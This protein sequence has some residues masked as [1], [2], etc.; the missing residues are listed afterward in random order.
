M[1][2]SKATKTVCPFLSMPLIADSEGYRSGALYKVMCMGGDCMTWEYTKT[3]K[4]KPCSTSVHKPAVKALEEQMIR[5]GYKKT[6]D[7]V[8]EWWTKELP[9]DEKEGYCK[10]LGTIQCT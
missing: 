9:E 8:S 4:T 1:K 6:E 5:D 7:G 3:H 10:R 2:V